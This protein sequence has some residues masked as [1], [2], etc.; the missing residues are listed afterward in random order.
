MKVC[1]YARQQC[2][3]LDKGCLRDEEL[4]PLFAS[5]PEAAVH[6]VWICEW[7][8]SRVPAAVYLLY[9]IQRGRLT[10]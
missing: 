7:A 5:N 8:G 9:L 10:V 3:W 6:E 1:S 4:R 2:R